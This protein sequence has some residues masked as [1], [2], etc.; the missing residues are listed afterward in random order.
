MGTFKIEFCG[1]IRELFSLSLIMRF[2]MGRFE[3]FS[4][5]L[6]G[7]SQQRHPRA[8]VWACM[9]TRGNPG[10]IEIEFCGKN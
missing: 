2:I 6:F 4:N 10:H 7:L 1:K 9:P 5:F 8:C 3:F